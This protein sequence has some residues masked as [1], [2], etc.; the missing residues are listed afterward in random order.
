MESGATGLDFVAYKNN[1]KIKTWPVP[2]RDSYSVFQDE[3]LAIHKAV[4]WGKTTDEPYSIRSDCKSA[5]NSLNKP[6][7]VNKTVD[8]I[9]K[10]IRNSNKKFKISWVKAHVGTLGLGNEE[11]D[12][13]AK[14][15]A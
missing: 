12:A 7:N 2:L 6:F 10:L 4:E 9:Q 1:R 15:A 3:L 5:I 8:T 11:A 13:L 14:N